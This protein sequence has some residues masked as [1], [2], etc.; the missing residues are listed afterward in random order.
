MVES[1]LFKS[2][3][4]KNANIEKKATVKNITNNF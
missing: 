4:F 2:K 3:Y 1:S